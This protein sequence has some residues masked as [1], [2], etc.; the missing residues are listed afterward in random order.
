MRA[1]ISATLALALV[2]LALNTLPENMSAKEVADPNAATT[3]F[4]VGQAEVNITPTLLGPKP[5][6]MAGFG[7]NRQARG[8]NDP[9]MARC[10]VLKHGQQKW[11]LVSAD[12]IGWFY[13]QT[14]SV[15]DKLK[16]FDYVLVSSTHNHEGPDT[17]GLWG[18]SPL[19]SG[20][21]PAYIAQVEALMVQAIRTAE[22]QCQPAQARIGRVRV[23]ELLHDS[24]QPYLV[25]DELV[26]LQF[27]RPHTQQPLG[28]VVQWNCHPETLSSQNVHIS[29][30]FV[31]YC[32]A[33]LHKQTQQPVTYFTGTVGGL[34]TSLR[35]KIKDQTG[36]EWQDGTI[37]K[38]RLYGEQLAAA[39]LRAIDSAVPLKMVPFNCRAQRI[40][41]PVTNPL[42]L[43]A[44]RLGVLQRETFH[45][46]K[47]LTQA[48]PATVQ[49][50][51]SE[52]AIAT[53]VAVLQLGELQIICVPGEIYPE[54]VLDQ[55]PLPLDA[56]ADF[57]DAP[58]E[59]PLYRML[60]RPHQM[61]I[62]LAND[63]VGY[64]I[65]KRQWDAKP[66][67][68]YGR[69]SKQYGEENS[70]GPE[71]APLLSQAFA[72]LLRVPSK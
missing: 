54:L 50:P 43:L 28:L 62:G 18:A 23:P 19:K 7:H 41:L 61:L 69:Q 57:P 65:P 40:Y 58:V 48:A 3:D 68:C 25:H 15:R 8:V 38:T 45:W 2:A 46:Q 20:V 52:Q 22:K 49:T 4:E 33:A 56:G 27:L 6:Y 39:A 31:G 9:L 12:L 10:L 71:T 70:L 17:M 66:P 63:E 53:E 37:E 16:D 30:D 29:A 24:R 72:E 13:P 34:M 60:K 11:A 1:L 55:P 35:V 36:K 32:V 14:L 47:Q 42:Y 21:D 51:E 44:R 64:I 67:F 5:V 59:P 26:V